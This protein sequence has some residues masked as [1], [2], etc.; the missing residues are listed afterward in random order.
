MPPNLKNMKG[1]KYAHVFNQWSR[2]KTF[3]LD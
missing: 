2:L 3:C 1:C